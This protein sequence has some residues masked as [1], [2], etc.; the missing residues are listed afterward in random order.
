MNQNRET[1][2]Y[3]TLVGLMSAL[4]TILYFL[5]IPVIGLFPYFL[6]V[7]LSEI[8]M[9]ITGFALGPIAGLFTLLFRFFISL[10]FSTTAYIGE[11]A[12]LVFSF[13]FII[14][15]VMIYQK[16]RS[17]RGVY[18]AFIV[19]MVLQLVVS[20]VL[21]A[22]VIT[23]L[24]LEYFLGRYNATAEDF[25]NIIRL[26]NPL[27]SDPY[28]SLVLYVYLPFNILKN[29][30]MITLTLITYKRLHL[31]IKKFRFKNR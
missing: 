25:V 24:Y 15:A 23:D 13:F 22:L 1:I 4:T 10:P 21:N 9:F 3:M 8:V 28:W 19:A 30:G 26:T 29:T 18:L 27:V 5:R 14:P 17:P 20:S 7:N 11:I 31:L 6:Q 16:N 2:R 12:D